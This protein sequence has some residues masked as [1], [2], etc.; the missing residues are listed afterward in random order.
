MTK[1]IDK[2]P[3][4][5]EFTDEEKAVKREKQR[6]YKN[7]FRSIPENRE[8]YNAYVRGFFRRKMEERDNG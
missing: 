4:K 2:K 8:K 3:S 5:R 1:V 6:V 7:K